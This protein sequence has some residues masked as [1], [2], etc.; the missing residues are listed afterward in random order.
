[1][2]RVLFLLIVSISILACEKEDE[3][4]TENEEVQSHRLRVKNDTLLSFNN[5]FIKQGQSQHHYGALQPGEISAYK[6]FTY[7]DFLGYPYVKV[8]TAG[9]DIEFTIQPV[10][11]SPTQTSQTNHTEVRPLTCVIKV[12]EHANHALDVYFVE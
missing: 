6:V 12:N 8:T 9:Q 4:S 5:V 3:A 10:D 7:V 2:K 1:M 11:A